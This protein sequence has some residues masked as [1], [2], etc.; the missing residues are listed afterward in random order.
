MKILLKTILIV[1]LFVSQV[2]ARV[3]CFSFEQLSHISDYIFIG[4]VIDSNFYQKD[5]GKFIK[6]YNKYE[7]DVEEDIKGTSSPKIVLDILYQEERMAIDMPGSPQ[8]AE[9][10]TYLLF[11]RNDNRF[12][13]V[14]GKQ[15]IFR[16][17]Y[18]DRRKAGFFVNYNGHLVVITEDNKLRHGPT[19]ILDSKGAL[20]ICESPQKE[21]KTIIK[22][23]K[24]ALQ[25]YIL[26]EFGQK[27]PLVRK[28]K[29][30]KPPMV[31]TLF[32]VEKS[33][34]LDFI[35]RT[36]DNEGMEGIITEDSIKTSKLPI[37]KCE[38]NQ[39]PN[40]LSG[41]G[42][43]IKKF[44]YVKKRPVSIKGS[45]Q[46]VQ[47]SQNKR[48]VKKRESRDS[49]YQVQRDSKVR[50]VKYPSEPQYSQQ[51]NQEKYMG[52]FSWSG[53]LDE[54]Y[55]IIEDFKRKPPEKGEHYPQILK[56][57][58]ISICD[59]KGKTAILVEPGCCDRFSELYDV[60]GNFICYPWGGITGR[61]DGKCKKEDL[62]C[63]NR[64]V[65]WNSNE[66]QHIMEQNQ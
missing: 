21:I 9:G 37:K 19:V 38:L 20:N 31:E 30:P 49:N 54:L 33:M 60:D 34:M 57:D 51:K 42:G 15:G 14:G 61:G 24:P 11:C 32:A 50:K 63:S 28:D 6:F 17:V 59:Y 8:L 25:P 66:F 3:I 52:S 13:I 47:L 27:I 41:P 64:K 53:G 35:Y 48:N 36:L 58:N 65:I 2:Q 56:A 26:D 43:K 1:F 23:K 18:D 55:K 62:N 45:A 5:I 4:K 7:I 44:S 39:N 40:F 10:E 12:P 16:I 29:T 22:P 46:A